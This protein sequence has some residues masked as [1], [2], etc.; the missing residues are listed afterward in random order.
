MEFIN[1]RV[2]D[3]LTSTDSST[4]EDPLV[5]SLHE[6]RNILIIPKDAPPSSDGGRGTYMQMFRLSW[7]VSTLSL[8]KSE[9]QKTH[10]N[11]RITKT[12]LNI[13]KFA[14]ELYR[15]VRKNHPVFDIIGDLEGNV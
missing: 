3:Y 12:L 9:L 7:K 15:K 8:R 14:Q 13:W 10:S 2:D 6:D 5:G 11:T 4:V 1:V